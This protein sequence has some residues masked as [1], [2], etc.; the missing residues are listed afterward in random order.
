MNA[1]AYLRVSSKGQTKG[2]GIDRQL[3]AIRRYATANGLRLAK[4]FRDEGVSGTLDLDNRPALLELMAGIGAK[5]V[6]IE[7]LDRLARDLMVQEAIITDL[8]KRGFTLISTTEPD[9][10]NDDPSRKLVRQ[11]FGAIAEYDRAMTVAKLR[12]ARERKK[13]RTGRCEGNKPYG[14]YPGESKAVRRMV[15]LRAAGSGYEQIATTL[16]VEGVA[17]RKGTAWAAATVRR[18]VLRNATAG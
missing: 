3:T 11:V 1:F 5:V 7:R 4:V 10:L 12:V 9:L 17:T 6:L 15:E 18:V 2:H 8:Q 14:F 13:A 16:G